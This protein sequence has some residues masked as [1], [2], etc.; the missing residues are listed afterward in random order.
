[1]PVQV[2]FPGVYVQ[3]V[4]SGVRT[5]TGVS[6]SIAMFI[7][8]TKRGRLRK[9]TRVLSP[10]DYERAFGTDT[11]ISEMTDQVRQFFTNGGQ[12]A[13]ITRIAKDSRVA[14]VQLMDIEG[15]SPVM[16][17]SAKEDGSQGNTI[18]VQV[19]YFTPDPETTFNLTVF[20][21]AA[22]ASGKIVVEVQEQFTSLSMNPQDG[23]FVENI[24]N[25]QSSLVDVTVDPDINE[26]I[27]PFQGNSL[28]GLLLN[29]S[30][31]ADVDGEINTILASGN[32]IQISVDGNPPVTVAL[33]QITETGAPSTPNF[34]SWQQAIN[35]AFSL[36]GATVAVE[37]VDDANGAPDG[38]QYL[39]IRS[40]RPATDPGE[41]SVVIKPAA[42][43]DAAVALQLGF[44]QGGLEVGGY[45]SQ[46]SAPT[47]FFARLGDVDPSGAI[48]VNLADFAAANQSDF[49]RWSLSDASGQNFSNNGVTFAGGAKMF[50]GTRFTPTTAFSGSLLNVQ[51]N[52]DRLAAAIRDRTRKFWTTAVHGRRLV[53]VPIFG[54]VNS[55]VT[56]RLTSDNG[57]GA[58]YNIGAPGGLFPPAAAPATVS[59]ANVRAYSLGTGSLGFQQA[60]LSGDDG[61]I[62][63][64]DEYEE[65][66]ER[67]D[68]EVDLFNLMILPRANGQTDTQREAV[69]GT[70]STFCLSR[71][72]FL[73][74]DPR[75]DGGAWSTV[76]EVESEIEELRIGLVTDHAAIYWPRLAVATNGTTKAIDPAGSI[77]GLMA[78]IDSNRGVWKAPAGIEADIR[79]I[80]GVQYAMSDPENGIINPEAVNAIRV[81]ATGIVSWGA[82][83]MGGFD[84]SGNDDY[85]YVPVRRLALFIEESLYRG[86]KFAVFQPN[87][88]PLWAQ[89]RVAAGAFMNNLFRQG[90]FQGQKA[91]DAFFVKV[92][93]ETTTQ[94]DINLGIVNV[95]VGFAPL[96]PA[97]FVVITIQQKAGQVQT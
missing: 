46:R 85:K 37:T 88:E 81:F 66:F 95:I 94:N 57:A 75:S 22:D 60:A 91:S 64:T 87:D 73:I 52:L 35:L 67:I 54:N 20:R 7:G 40:A 39:R 28:S 43:N 13:F 8:M 23:R 4:P 10:T 12:Q 27:P 71:R 74:V 53:L 19:D 21:E 56:A 6:T 70:A 31:L 14:S 55:D 49:K 48:L 61:Q 82:R 86:L 76:N 32:N 5:V 16:T 80:R 17:V 26:N 89:I 2:T 97:E 72:A 36:V 33:P 44:R 93:S 25:G 84:N 3:E 92:D 90:A 77:A 38:T 11:T 78:R 34:A 41:R 65:A 68:R 83:T 51:E 79:G 15:I 47:G 62:P 45:A 29:A 30:S 24:V 18:R 42:S 9:P 50:N 59:S 96:K 63:Q 58:G 69:W 1:M